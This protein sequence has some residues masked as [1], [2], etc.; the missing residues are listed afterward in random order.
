MLVND[1]LGSGRFLRRLNR[2]LVQLDTLTGERRC[3]LRDP[4]R[5]S[6]LLVP[7]ATVVFKERRGSSGRKTDC[8]VL[9]VWDGKVWTVVNSGL[10]STLAEEVL[11]SSFLPELSGFTKLRREVRF[12]DSRVDFLLEGV[13]TTLLEVKGCTLVRNGKALFPDAPT[14]RGRRHILNLIKALEGGYRTAVL[15]LV[16]RPDAS[17]FSPNRETDPLFFEA[18]RRAVERGVEVYALNFAYRD[19]RIFPVR[20]IP[21][22]I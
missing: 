4:G 17:E 8:E 22:V 12:G 5:L 16:M 18:L 14:E 6:E 3:H 1:E 19:R 7:G 9:L 15:F 2:F 10:H 11:R 20:R 21:V 13:T